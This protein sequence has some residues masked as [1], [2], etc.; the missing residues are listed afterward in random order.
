M[1]ELTDEGQDDTGDARV[2]EA[3]R[4]LETLD[5]V[6]VHQHADVIDDV[7]RALQDRLAA[8]PTAESPPTDAGPGDVPPG[9]LRADAEG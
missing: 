3:L 1:R 4:A 6:P 9:D 2:D 5:R 7:H 8:D